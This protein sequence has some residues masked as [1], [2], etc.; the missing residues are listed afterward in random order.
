MI[1]KFKVGDIVTTKNSAR[2]APSLKTF[3]KLIITTSAVLDE[4]I[5]YY[6]VYS[7]H[8]D[9]YYGFYEYELEHVVKKIVL[10]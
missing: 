1:K 6:E 9:G 4:G 5:P 8:I 2:H 10:K 7:P 3:A